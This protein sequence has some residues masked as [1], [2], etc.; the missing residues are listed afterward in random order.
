M[1]D[2]QRN[3]SNFGWL[4]LLVIC[5]AIFYLCVLG[6]GC[7]TQMVTAPVEKVM[8]E[9]VRTVDVLGTFSSF[10]LP[11]E[12]ELNIPEFGVERKL[13]A[14]IKDQTKPVDKTTWFSFD[15]LEFETGSS[16]LKPSSTEQLKNIAEIL[17]A[18]PEVTLKL[19]GYTD[20]TGNSENNLKLSQQRAEATMQEL[21][22]LEIEA[23]RLEAEGYGEQHPIADNATEEG[24]QKNRRIDLRVTNK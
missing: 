11:N 4:L 22:K 3:E 24:K 19:G 13:I 8:T 1:S 23:N 14:F 7:S 21:I 17:K 12:V 20:N 15:R 18:Y 2:Q 9:A 5:S 16:V 10:K 6:K